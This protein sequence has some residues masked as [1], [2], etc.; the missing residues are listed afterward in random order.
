MKSEF[1]HFDDEQMNLELLSRVRDQ[2]EIMDIMSED[3]WEDTKPLIQK[4]LKA[5]QDYR[6]SC[7]VI[8]Q[9]FDLCRQVL[10]HRLSE[11]EVIINNKGNLSE[12]RTQVLEAITARM[13]TEQEKY[14]CR[15]F[16]P[17]EYA[18]SMKAGE[19]L[20]QSMLVFL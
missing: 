20:G 18:H 2:F 13:V 17:T 5:I 8:L 9:G 11:V 3:S 14:C 6:K 16:Y 4:D 1:D 12:I 10:E 7:C 19:G 15:F